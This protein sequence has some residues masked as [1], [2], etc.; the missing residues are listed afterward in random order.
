MQLIILAS[1]RGLRLG[2]YTRNKPKCLVNVCNNTIISYIMPAFKFYKEIIFISGYKSEI[3]KKYL[4][5]IPNLLFLENL[6]FSSTNMVESLFVCNKYVNEDV[7]VCYSDIIFDLNILKNI[8]KC[9]QSTITIYKNW[10]KLW[11][12]RM[13][14]NEILNDA[15]ELKFNGKKITK[16]GE[17]IEKKL[18]QYQFMGITKLMKNDYKKLSKFYFSSGNKKIDF[19][20]FLNEAINKKIIDLYH[21]KTDKFWIEIDSEKDL[22]VAENTLKTNFLIEQNMQ[23]F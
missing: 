12:K 9:K 1:G 22:S 10:L 5:N 18:P 21:L 17:K 15:E 3:L 23:L 11:E 2:K 7:V 16:I 8:N 14:K 13:N 19:T 4:K 20:N 6:N